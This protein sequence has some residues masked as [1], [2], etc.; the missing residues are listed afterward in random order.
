MTSTRPATPPASAALAR[1]NRPA[2]LTLRWIVRSLLK[3]PAHLVKGFRVQGADRLPRRRTRLILA[4]NHAAFIDSVYLILAA[5]TRFTICGA[6]PRLFRNTLFRFA[7]AL[8]NILKV[9]SREQFLGD[10]AALLAAG[11]TLLIYPEMGRN[12]AALGEFK[13][14]A[15]EVALAN[16]VPIL[17]CYLYGTTAGQGGPP[18]LYVGAPIEPRGDAEDLTAGL[19]RA[20]LDLAPAVRTEGSET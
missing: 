9:E 15:A 7:M 20:I 1:V 3:A 4:C 8:A 2:F 11:E 12:T 14:W 19:R 16:R 13:T 18:R 6:K 10:T 17:P 5:R